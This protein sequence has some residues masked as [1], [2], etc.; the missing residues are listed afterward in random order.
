MGRLDR[1]PGARSVTGALARQRCWT[2][3]QREAVSRCPSCTRY[4]CREC[5]TEH[6]GHLLCKACLS[7]LIVP[8]AAR[9]GTRWIVWMCAALV[10][11]VAAFAWHGITGYALLQLPP[12]WTRGVDGE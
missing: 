12:A 2:H 1:E 11:L 8:A 5:V 10:G 4:Y 7:K 9:A 6:E 3:A